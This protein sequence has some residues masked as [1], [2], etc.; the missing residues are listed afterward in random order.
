LRP[1]ILRTNVTPLV[2]FLS[3]IQSRLKPGE[4]LEGRRILDCG[5]AGPIPPVALFA[6]QG[7]ATWALD[8]SAGGLAKAHAFAAERELS[9]E[10]VHGD[11]R[12][13]PFEN[14]F[15]DYVYEIY[16]MCHLTKADT[17]RAID[18]MHRVLRPGGFAFL[19]V[20]STDS[21]P[22]L[23]FGEEATPGEF[24]GE[25]F[26]GERARHSMFTETEAD[27]LVSR[28]EILSKEKRIRYLLD[29]AEDL[30][31]EAWMELRE[32]ARPRVTEAAWRADYSKRH[33]ACLYAHVHFILRKPGS[34]R[35]GA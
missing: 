27:D 12:E 9:I 34:R 20:I 15:F 24:V 6:E 3:L 5:G 23:F 13:M 26:D 29:S 7:M 19:G 1:I 10:L 28:W 32:S 21:W 25:E 4:S 17:Q 14:A 35:M 31:E 2:A 8:I 18:E 30:S 33:N 16:S 22:K 11:M